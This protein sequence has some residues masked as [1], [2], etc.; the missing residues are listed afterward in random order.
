MS[1]DVRIHPSARSVIIHRTETV[2][3]NEGRR[4]AGGTVPRSGSGRPGIGL[5]E[6]RFGRGFAFRFHRGMWKGRVVGGLGQSPVEGQLTL[7]AV[8]AA[9]TF[10]AQ[11]IAAHIFGAAGA[12]LGRRLF[13]DT[14]NK[15]HGCDYFFP[16]LDPAFD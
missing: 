9:Q 6:W 15:W 16:P 11:M 8:A 2:C 4:K 13:A 7:T 5:F 12:D 3:G 1:P 10:L 14:A